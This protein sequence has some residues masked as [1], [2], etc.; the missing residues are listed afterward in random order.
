VKV[1]IKNDAT[2]TDSI[3]TNSI[4]IVA[5]NT[6]TNSAKIDKKSGDSQ[7]P[8]DVIFVVEGDHVKTVPVKIGI[9]DDNFWEVTDGL[10]EGDEIVT[11]GYRAISRDLD[12]GKKIAKGLAGAKTDPAD[13][14]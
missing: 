3:P 12:D 4:S 9:S 6:L 14:K 1:K 8:V 7:K 13:S 5:T 11:G 10:K 2:K